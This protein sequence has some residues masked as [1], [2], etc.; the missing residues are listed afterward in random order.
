M[1][2][3]NIRQTSSVD[4]DL[5]INEVRVQTL[6]ELAHFHAHLEPGKAADA[7]ASEFFHPMSAD[8]SVSGE[9]FR[10]E[11]VSVLESGAQAD[12]RFAAMTIA[13]AYCV[14]VSRLLA[15]GMRELAWQNMSD[16]RYW[17][18]V[19]LASRGIEDARSA[20]I[21][22]TRKHTSD[23]AA[24]TRV[25]ERLAVQY[26]AIMFLAV[27]GLCSVQKLCWAT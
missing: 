9:R 16:A 24:A 17:C 10:A 13:C 1:E 4:T 27:A 3:N 26:R 20:T 15:R 19:T 22:A 23:K 12:L 25:D 8:P 5:L 21:S 7:F 6:G 11:F 2:D 14:D 18:G